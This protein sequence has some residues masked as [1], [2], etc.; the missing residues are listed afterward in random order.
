MSR[1]VVWLLVGLIGWTSTVAADPLYTPPDPVPLDPPS[2]DRRGPDRPPRV[3]RPPRRP[4]QEEVEAKF[5]SGLLYMGLSPIYLLE[6]PLEGTLNGPPLI[7]TI[8]GIGMGLMCSSVMGL[9]G[10][11]NAA[12]SWWPGW[13]IDAR[14]HYPSC[15]LG[16]DES[17]FSTILGR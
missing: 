10:V 15:I 13:M 1:S 5:T 3:A 8:G 7:G 16:I 6:E 12:T 2:S 11:I 4:Y 14:R 17:D 9:S